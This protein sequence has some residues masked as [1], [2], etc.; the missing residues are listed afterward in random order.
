[1]SMPGVV[2]SSHLERHLSSILAKAIL[3]DCQ[4]LLWGN[5][6]LPREEWLRLVARDLMRERQAKAEREVLE[7]WAV[8]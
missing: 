3:S 1:M 8:R 5:K 7:R 6:M 2:R 4:E